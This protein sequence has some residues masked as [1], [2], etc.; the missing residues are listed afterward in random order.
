MK[1]PGGLSL[2]IAPLH[3][4]AFLPVCMSLCVFFVPCCPAIASNVPSCPSSCYTSSPL[5][6]VTLFYYLNVC[7]FNN[8]E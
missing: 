2:L 1:N 8:D 7:L 5:H 6:S 3:C 4:R